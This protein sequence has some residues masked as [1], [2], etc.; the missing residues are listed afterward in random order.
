MVIAR[1]QLLISCD[2]VAV[3]IVYAVT[4][5][6][7]LKHS[8]RPLEHGFNI[9]AF[10]LAAVFILSWVGRVIMDRIDGYN[11]YCHNR[12]DDPH[13][14]YRGTRKQCLAWAPKYAAV[15]WTWVALTII[16]W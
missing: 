5:L 16:L 7:R 12:L 4:N 10:G 13:Y 2:Q 14:S 15:S 8:G 11:E 9:I 3:A 1:S 6:A